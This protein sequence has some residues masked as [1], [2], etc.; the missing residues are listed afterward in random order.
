MKISF[1]LKSINGKNVIWQQENSASVFNI[2][3]K[4]Q[5]LF[6]IIFFELTST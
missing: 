5:L 6:S 1:K 2:N 4:R 3:Y